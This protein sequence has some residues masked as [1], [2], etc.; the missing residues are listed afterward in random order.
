MRDDEASM[1][2]SV[3][4]KKDIILIDS[5]RVVTSDA[6]GYD[7]LSIDGSCT[8]YIDGCLVRRWFFMSSNAACIRGLS[9]ILN[10][11]NVCEVFLI[12][13]PHFRRSNAHL[14][15]FAGDLQPHRNKSHVTG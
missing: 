9:L 7:C 4:E 8:S 11:S 14:Q 6:N 2:I 1:G 12:D 10:H 5:A 13:E 3:E 15:G